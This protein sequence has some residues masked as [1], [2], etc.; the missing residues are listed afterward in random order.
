VEWK[1]VDGE[2]P[3]NQSCIVTLFTRIK[4]CTYSIAGPTPAIHSL[5]II[6]F[7]SPPTSRIYSQNVTNPDRAST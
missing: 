2:V 1:L 4:H 3:P 7:F 6:T 5:S